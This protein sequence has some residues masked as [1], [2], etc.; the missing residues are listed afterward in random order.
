MEDPERK[1]EPEVVIVWGKG[2]ETEKRA[3]LKAISTGAEPLPDG[4]LFPMR[5]DSVEVKLLWDLVVG[6]PFEPGYFKASKQLLD[7][8]LRPLGDEDLLL[9]LTPGTA[10]QEIEIAI[11]G[12]INSIDLTFEEKKILHAIEAAFSDAA[13]GGDYPDEIKMT[14]ANLYDHLGIEW[15]E[16]PGG[17]RYRAESHGYQRRRI[18]KTMIALSDKPFPFI[19]KMRS[20]KFDKK[21]KEALW[22][23]AL[24]RAP[25]IR[26]SKIYEDV[27]QKEMPGISQQRAAGD[28]RFSHY[29][30]R[31][32]KCAIGEIEHYFR[33][34]PRL[35]AKN[36][37]DYR[38]SM[39]TIPSAAELNFIEY[40]FTE[41]REVIEINFLRLAK[42]LK[43]KN[44]SHPN[45]VRTTLSRCY[46][47]AKALG[48]VLRVEKD[49][50]ALTGTKDIIHLNPAKFRYLRRVLP[51]GKEAPG[52]GDE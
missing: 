19:F 21:T 16:R 12:G 8:I 36:I 44:L 13:A 5:K 35:L 24:T 10:R 11:Q 9:P 2:T 14:R 30:V 18:D 7:I 50:E 48:Y 26:V 37:S 4:T 22:T 27:R 46:E 20:G 28:K 15:R 51:E 40:L 39:G 49:Q 31:L 52:E 38:R 1:K 47:T 23:V 3:R 32:N 34:I 41:S 6:D 17:T 43:V 33:Y 25:I 45:E 29:Q 42:K